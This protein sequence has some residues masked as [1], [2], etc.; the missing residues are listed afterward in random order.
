MKTQGMR[1]DLEENGDGGDLLGVRLEAVAEV[2]PVREVQT[3]DA[4]VRL[5]QCREHLH[6]L[7][8][9]A[10]KFTRPDNTSQTVFGFLLSLDGQAVLR[11]SLLSA[12]FSTVSSW[13]S[14]SGSSE[15]GR[16]L[17]IAADGVCERACLEVGGRARQRLHID[18]PLLRVQPE[19]LQGPFLCDTIQP[20]EPCGG[21]CWGQRT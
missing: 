16:A 19:C 2:A 7:K 12:F 9:S 15:S 8:A 17:A 5:Q 3:H 11:Q 6:L 18:A 20:Y 4:L 13:S 1:T 14:S 21:G 10:L